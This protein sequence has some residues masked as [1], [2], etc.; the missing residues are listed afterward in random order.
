ML[1]DFTWEISYGDRGGKRVKSEYTDELVRG[2]DFPVHEEM[3]SI[4]RDM[5]VAEVYRQE[6]HSSSSRE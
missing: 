5:W 1:T 3:A 4:V 6:R 2:L